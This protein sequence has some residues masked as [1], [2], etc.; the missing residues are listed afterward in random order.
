MW[1]AVTGQRPGLQGANISHSMHLELLHKIDMS[2]EVW[3]G[4]G[5][6]S[7]WSQNLVWWFYWFWWDEED[8]YFTR[9]AEIINIV[10]DL[11]K[12]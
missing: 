2:K 3:G 10:Y 9:E 8:N 11:D 6:Y 1:Q 5:H 12:D 4:A 7:A